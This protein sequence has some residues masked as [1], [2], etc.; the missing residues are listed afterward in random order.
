MIAITTLLT[1][2]DAHLPPRGIA[3][4]HVQTRVDKTHFPV[5]YDMKSFMEAEFSRR[6]LNKAML[7]DLATAS[8]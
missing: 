7:K 4:L 6:L 2:T 5:K 1:L 8:A 3:P